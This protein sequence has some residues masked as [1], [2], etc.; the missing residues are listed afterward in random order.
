[1]EKLLTMDWRRLSTYIGILLLDQILKFLAFEGYTLFTTPFISFSLVAN[2]GA[3][4][5]MLQGANDLLIL[6]SI[7]ALVMIAY[8]Y[9]DLEEEEQTPLL[10]IA[11]GVTGNL[12]D[13]VAHGFVI[14]YVNLHWWPVFNVADMAIVGG[15]VYL[16]WLSFNE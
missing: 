5:G 15:V 4:F 10:V 6:V 16:L 9:R 13:R 2:T 11:A 3:S 14:D 1:M 12:I 8:Y 7:A